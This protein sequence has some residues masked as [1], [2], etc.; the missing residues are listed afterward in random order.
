M[1]AGCVQGT[2][3]LIGE[4]HRTLATSHGSIGL[5]MN[6]VELGVPFPSNLTAGKVE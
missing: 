6:Q 5:E 3:S 1:L 2:S 4:E